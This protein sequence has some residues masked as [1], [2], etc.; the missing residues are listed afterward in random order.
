M[1]RWGRSPRHDGDV[2]QGATLA[3]KLHLH[4]FILYTKS[5]N[6]QINELRWL[7]GERPHNIK[8]SSGKY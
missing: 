6:L 2:P 4:Y 7:L 5:K 1:A 3:Q 8:I